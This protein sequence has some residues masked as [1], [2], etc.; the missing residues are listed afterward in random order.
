M[1]PEHDIPA[2]IP[3]T[4]SHPAGW[5][6]PSVEELQR[7]LTQYEVIELI[8]RGGMGAV[9][10]ARQTSLR[11]VV[12]LKILPVAV[13]HDEL[14]F[15]ERFKNEA[16]TMA[17]L[18]HPGIVNVHD[19]GE[20][21]DGLLYFAMEF[22]D[23]RDL[24]RVI[25]ERGPLPEDEVRSIALQVSEALS[26]AHE[27]G[28]LHRDIKPANILLDDRG[29]V[30]VADFGLAKPR[31]PL[32]ST[33]L[34]RTGTSMGTVEFMAPEARKPGGVVD[35]R[36]DVFSLGVTIY[37][38]LTGEIPSGM[39][40]LPSKKAPGV[41]EGFD[42]IICR[43]LEQEPDDRYASAEEMRRDLEALGQPA[44]HKTDDGSRSPRM[45][46]A[47]L[48]LLAF[49]GCAV[50]AFVFSANKNKPATAAA[51]DMASLMRAVA[52]APAEKHAALLEAKLREIN[53]VEVKVSATVR[54][55]ATNEVTVNSPNEV[56]EI[57]PIAALT[58][59]R[60]LN[61]RAR[62]L[63]DI[64]C[65][66]GLEL[67]RLT[68]WRG[69]LTDVSVLKDMPTL[70]T[71]DFTDNWK[72]EAEALQGV[73]VAWLSIVGCKRVTNLSFV[74]GMPLNYLD[75]QRTGVRDLSPLAGVPITELK[76]DPKC[77]I[78]AAWLDTVPTLR[79]LN[80]RPVSEWRK[81]LGMEASGVPV[82]KTPSKAMHPR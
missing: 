35:Q 29:K 31:E 47:A 21:V 69:E 68:V 36:A 7:A 27:H 17:R 82:E 34:T 49:T 72:L 24:A 38:M 45:L 59:V 8:G 55:S 51:D 73:K 52:S 14:R 75:I 56:R 63:R 46:R 18:N 57:W 19:A 66:N 70:W 61:L 11:R 41:S 71:L 48:F 10:K 58:A 13:A 4:P 53:G 64:S 2:P 39:F 3:K 16:F 44:P 20:T 40:K 26:Y 78:N 33:L 67:E 76:C 9:Y 28:V 6:A 65:L 43:A 81:D 5:L 1:N 62:G 50:G 60:T 74:K 42:E 25:A 15:A 23:G 54:N 12:A 32:V 37:Q 79:M 80:G 77:N 30:K 22:V